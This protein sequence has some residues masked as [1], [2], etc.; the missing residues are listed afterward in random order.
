M[1]T[2]EQAQG[3]VGKGWAEI[4]EVCW[5]VCKTCTEVNVFITQVKEKYGSL[6][7]YVSSAPSYVYHVIDAMEEESSIVCELC[8]ENGE[9]TDVHG[10]YKTLCTECYKEAWNHV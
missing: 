10:W 7:F 6:R 8:G 5:K 1:Y 4:V 9:T 3:S 2:L